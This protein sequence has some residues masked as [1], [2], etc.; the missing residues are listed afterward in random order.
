M[1]KWLIF[2]VIIGLMTTFFNIAFEYTADDSP[3]DFVY[4]LFI[5]VWSI[6][7]ITKW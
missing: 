5:M 6:F 4:A 1:Q 7:F 3:G 2:P